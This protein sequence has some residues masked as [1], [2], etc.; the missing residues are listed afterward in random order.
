MSRE[1]RVRFLTSLRRH[2]IWIRRH[3]EVSDINGNHYTADLNGQLFGAALWPSDRR[4]KQW[5]HHAW[6]GLR[7]ELTKQFLPSGE[8][9]EA[10]TAYHRLVLELFAL[11]TLQGRRLGLTL[12]SRESRRLLAASGHVVRYTRPDGLAPLQGDADDA[13]ALPLWPAP[14]RAHGHVVSLVTL[15]TSDHLSGADERAIWTAEVPAVA[16]PCSREQPTVELGS[17]SCAL[18]AR[19]SH[20]WVDC[21]GVGFCGRGGHG[22]NDSLS[23]EAYLSGVPLI[24]ERGCYAYTRFA[25]ERNRD[26]SVQSHNTPQMDLRSNQ[27]WTFWYDEQGLHDDTRVRIMATGNSDLGAWIEVQHD[28]YS[29]TLASATVSRSLALSGSGSVAAVGRSGDG[30]DSV[31]SDIPS[32]F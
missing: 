18:R 2:C 21:G 13:R 24:S 22:H 7:S 12:D 20:V 15:A 30:G 32:P 19:G 6:D 14:I 23:F 3:L 5:L 27:I 1:F 11:G 31:Q 29:H 8:N 26:R 16:A 10:S 17:D 9:V 28:G 4:A 25:D